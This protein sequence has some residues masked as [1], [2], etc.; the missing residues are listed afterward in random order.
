MMLARETRAHGSRADEPC[1]GLGQAWSRRGDR[2][3]PMPTFDTK[4]LSNGQKVDVASPFNSPR[5]FAG[6]VMLRCFSS[7]PEN[8]ASNQPESRPCQLTQPSQ[9]EARPGLSINPS[10][11]R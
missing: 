1:P 2:H 9:P 3:S 5:S 7:F 10:E 11:S 8:N 4:M 6:A